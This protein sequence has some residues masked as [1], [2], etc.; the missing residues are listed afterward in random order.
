[1]TAVSNLTLELPSGVVGLVGAKGAGRSTLIKMLLY[2]L[3]WEGVLAGYAPGV[4]AVSIREWALSP[5]E[6]IVDDP[7]IS[8][9]SDVG[10]VAGLILLVATTA[11][12]TAISIQR[13]KSISL[14]VS[15]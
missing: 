14:R 5:A 10:L 8:L 9:T 4:R 1:M 2:A 13:A 11:A 12:A 3:L 7:S 6:R 15:D